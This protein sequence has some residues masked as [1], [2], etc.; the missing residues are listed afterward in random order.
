MLHPGALSQK[1]FKKKLYLAL[2]KMAGL[3][4]R[5]DFHATDAREQQFILQAFGEQA[6]VFIAGNFPR[7]F[8]FQQAAQK[9]TGKLRLVSVALISPMKNILLVLEA[10]HFCTA[11]ISYDIYGPI[12][13]GFYW[14]LCRDKIKM[15]P[16][17][18]T[19]C[20]HGDVLP[21]KIEAVLNNYEV[22]ILPSKSENFGHAIYEA[23]SAGK[24]VI[25]SNHTP[26]NNLQ[27]NHAGENISTKNISEI[28]TAINFFAAMSAA[29]FKSWNEGAKSYASRQV[30]FNELKVQNDNMFLQKF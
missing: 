17:N 1:S 4:R 20:H 8:N 6:R 22:F 14:Q 11:E 5:Y 3:H 28:T 16:A 25:T 15:L 30:D 24:P 12:K 21:S 19:V 2:W 10:L 29:E 7:V 9:E 27:S 13:D 18:I 23:L 26:F